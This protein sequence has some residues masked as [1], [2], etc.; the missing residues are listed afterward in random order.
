MLHE[1]ESIG[2]GKAQCLALTVEMFYYYYQSDNYAGFKRAVK[3]LQSRALATGFKQYYYFGM[4]N[5]VNYL[6]LRKKRNEA[7]YYVQKFEEDSRKNKDMLGLFGGLNSLGQVY[8]ERME[9]GAANKV[10]YEAL[11][12]GRKY[13]KDQDMSSVLYKI[14]ENFSSMFDYEHMYNVAE[15]GMKYTKT[16]TATLR[17]LKQMT[18]ASLKQKKY[19]QARECINRYMKLSG[20]I[21]TLPDIKEAHDNELLV[22]RD[23]INRNFADAQYRIDLFPKG[24]GR[25]KLRLQMA[26]YDMKGDM[27]SLAET[28]NQ[29]YNSWL[30]VKDELHAQDV[31]EMNAQF[32]N[33]KL[34]FDNQRLLLEHQRMENEHRKTEIN[35]AKLKLS[36]TEL[37]L[38]NSSLEL[39]KAKADAKLINLSYANKQLEAK[40]LQSRLEEESLK[41]K[42]TEL[43][44]T[45]AII[46]IAIVIVFGLMY[47]RI[48]R[49]IMRNLRKVHTQLMH[50]H[51]ELEEARNKAVAADRV[52]TALIQNMTRDIN[53]PLDSII[54]FAA[55]IA[56][57]KTDCTPE[58]KSEYNRQILANTNQMLKIV[59]D[60]LEKAQKQE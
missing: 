41:H 56:D 10:L 1:A 33:Q 13:H 23:I 44:L 30:N 9:Y 58:K 17:F 57:R 43:R 22:M 27:K 31:Y 15:D 21:D 38:K 29:F 11:A 26:L 5:T 28:K 45:A 40:Q 42:T 25:T 35:N 16:K 51:T 36:N 55:L 46:V 6:L 20:P 24:H 19:D 53:I 60:V 52:K 12:I 48:H 14:A 49:R 32:F 4:T 59:K 7:M 37:S 54:G 8:S 2:D 34:E 50:N 3:K 39:G 47:A 18:F